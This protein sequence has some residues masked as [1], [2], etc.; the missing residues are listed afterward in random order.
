MIEEWPNNN[1]NVVL[2][3]FGETEHGFIKSMWAGLIGG[4]T[5]KC[6][7]RRVTFIRLEVKVRVKVEVRGR[8]S[9]RGIHT[10]LIY[11]CRKT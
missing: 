8:E 10:S 7:S 5:Y 3:C 1:V 4:V 11:K 6:G 9:R 2:F